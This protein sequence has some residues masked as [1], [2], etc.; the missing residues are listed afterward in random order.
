MSD[1]KPVV[2]HGFYENELEKVKRFCEANKLSLTVSSYKVVLVDDAEYSNKGIKVRLEDERKGM[3]FV[4]I[5]KDE[6][7]SVLAN[8][9]EMKNNHAQLGHILGYPKCCVEFFV[10]H[11]PHRSKLD[12]DYVLP[13]LENSEGK[14][15]SFY[16][17]ILLREQDITLLN[18]FPCSFG[19][20]ESSYLG[21]MHLIA[22]RKSNTQLADVFVSKLKGYQ[23]LYRR[24]LKFI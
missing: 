3:L 10:K 6:E 11:E 14:T 2:R 12:N 5:S 1:I 4:Y 23:R 13:A 17:N 24:I 7:K 21:K 15:F 16:N 22:L 19:C 20:G 9:Y 8:C 18:H